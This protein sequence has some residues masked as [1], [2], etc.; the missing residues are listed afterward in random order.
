MLDLLN[1]PEAGR[2]NVGRCYGT[3][4]C[5]WVTVPAFRPLAMGVKRTLLPPALYVH[6]PRT[7]DTQ[8]LF[9]NRA[10]CKELPPV[11]ATF[12]QPRS[13]RAFMSSSKSPRRLTSLHAR[14]ARPSIGARDH[15]QR[16]STGAPW[17]TAV[18]ACRIWRG[19]KA[20]TGKPS[21]STPAPSSPMAGGLGS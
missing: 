8:G 11:Q 15:K 10:I 6:S 17:S 19:G 18:G 1:S 14:A 7:P 3:N 9:T 16:S 13:S 12:F 5:F 21:R 2:F 20:V 4:S